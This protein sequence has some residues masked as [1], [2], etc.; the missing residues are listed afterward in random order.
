MDTGGENE[1]P[2]KGGWAQ[3]TQERLYLPA[4]LGAPQCPAGSGRSG[5]FCL[6]CCSRDPAPDKWKKMDD[7]LSL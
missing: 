6:S 2:L 7:L 3:N 1:L 4:G 5:L